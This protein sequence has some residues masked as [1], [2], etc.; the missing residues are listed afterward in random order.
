M[1]SKMQRPVCLLIWLFLLEAQAFEIPINGNSEVSTV[2]GLLAIG[3]DKQ[4]A[5]G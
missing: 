2:A 5:N 3:L 1:S 4:A